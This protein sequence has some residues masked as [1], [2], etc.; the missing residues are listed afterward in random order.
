MALR[1][2]FVDLDLQQNKLKNTTFETVDTSA[3]TGFAGQ[4]AFDSTTGKLAFYNG[5]TSA[6]EVLGQ[7]A[8]DTVN[9]K[10]SI[11][12]NAT[13]PSGMNTGDMYI[14]SSAGQVTWS[15]VPVGTIVQSGDFA[16][17]N[18]SEFDIIQGNVIA[19][20][21]T[22][23]GYVRLATQTEANTGSDAATA[24]SPATLEGVRTNRKFVQSVSFTA[25]AIGTSG[26]ALTH[27][28]NSQNVQ[29]TVYDSADAQIEVAVVAT[30]ANTVTL[31]SNVALTGTRVVVHGFKA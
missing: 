30:D 2:F 8:V 5:S 7:L 9:Y 23:A 15:T 11:A 10:G 29:V 17:Y 16:I 31:T 1:K 3:V 27:N 22:E 25:Q 26:T 18:G 13:A 14:F 4:I 6:W 19:A 28:L 20:S 12:H 24:I 21:T